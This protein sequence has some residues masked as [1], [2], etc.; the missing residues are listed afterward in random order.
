MCKARPKRGDGD[1]EVMEVKREVRNR[2][3]RDVC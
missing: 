2:H 1:D 3:P